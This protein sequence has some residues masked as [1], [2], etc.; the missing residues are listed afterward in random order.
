MQVD[1]NSRPR[2]LIHRPFT[3]L[4]FL[5]VC[6]DRKLMVPVANFV[7]TYCALFSG[8]EILSCLWKGKLQDNR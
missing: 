2:L 8:R 7:I 1:S 3:M 5:K 6:Q 4:W